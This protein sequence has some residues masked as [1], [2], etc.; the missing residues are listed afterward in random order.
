MRANRLGI[1]IVMLFCLLAAGVV[2]DRAKDRMRQRQ[3]G[4]SSTQ[5][6]SQP[7]DAS[8]SSGQSLA[9]LDSYSLG[10]LLGGLRGP[11]VMLLWTSSESQKNDREL[12]DFDTK[13]ELIGKL[14]P[15]FDTVHLFQVWN[16]AY[17]VSVQMANLPSKYSVV[18]GAIDYARERLGERPENMNMESEIARIFFDKLGTSSEKAYYR[19]RVRDDTLPL[20]D[21]TKLIFPADQ[22]KKF[23]D[24]ALA[25]GVDGRRFTLRREPDGENLS[26]TLRSDLAEP[27][28][29][30]LKDP[31]IT[32][33]KI[34]PKIVAN[35][36]GKTTRTRL[37]PVLDEQFRILPDLAK[38]ALIDA[39]TNA[40]GDHRWRP[41]MGPLAYLVKYEPFPDGVSTF[42]LSY[43][44][45]K[46][47]V[48]LMLSRDQHHAQMSDR[49]ISSRPAMCLKN[50]AEEEYDRGRRSEAAGLG[51]RAAPDIDQNAIEML[52]A[53][54]P[55]DRVPLNPL[56]RDAMY[57]YARSAA[58]TADSIEE[59]RDH[60]L[61]NR[62]DVQ[63][64]ASHMAWMRTL[65]YLM[66]AD[67]LFLTVLTT[68]GPER[69]EAAT[70]AR[71][72]Y[73]KASD[74]AL[75]NGLVFFAPE[76][77]TAEYYPPGFTRADVLDLNTAMPEKM[78]A[79]M[80]GE[81]FAKSFARAQLSNG[82][83]PL[84][85]LNEF[86]AYSR[87]SIFRATILGKMLDA[88]GQ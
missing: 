26:A 83:F 19:Q 45:Y 41:E 80:V 71:E 82:M 14:Q 87:R 35:S 22:A 77:L 56:L 54:Q 75:R 18:L 3:A 23:T 9:Q 42:A 59:Y 55:L 49:V 76:E 65:Q 10:L 84:D 72:L 31:T 24:A 61:R 32:A 21:L 51:L 60:L 53:E 5:P 12:E 36:A 6:T 15:E 50:W 27:L 68:D 29:A 33:Q 4:G 86:N 34:S 17:N 64:Y 48:A 28:M 52:A 79:P 73:L 46:R 39:N 38:R 81:I 63:T 44:Y 74:M 78:S 85:E 1:V 8:G 2:R 57:S 69:L 25:A 43:N 11:L 70:Q 62:D 7:L 16:K 37:D 88:A 67:R 47:S 58:V 20:T 40:A 30:T 13:I 66:L